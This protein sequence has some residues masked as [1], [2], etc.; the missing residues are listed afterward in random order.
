[1][2]VNAV[3]TMLRVAARLILTKNNVDGQKRL[4]S[5]EDDKAANL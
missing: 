5:G 4:K 3:N 1:M 2:L